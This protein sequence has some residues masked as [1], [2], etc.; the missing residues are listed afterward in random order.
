MPLRLTI[1]TPPTA[2]P[3]H[4]TDAKLHLRLATTAA[5]AALYTDEDIILSSHISAARMVA[6]TETWKALV[7]R[8]YDLVIDEWPC[9]EIA[10]PMPPLRAVDSITYTTTDGVEHTLAATEY[11]VD[12]TTH[13]GRVILG[14]DKEWPTDELT[15]TNP[16]RIRYRAG[17]AVP[18]T[19]NSTT[20]VITAVNHPFA[21][22]D[23]VRVSVTGGSLPVGLYAN[24]DYYA[25]DV[26]GNTLKLSAASGGTAIDITSAGTGQFFFGE[27]P[28]TT[29]IGMKLVI[30][31]LYE[32]R[33][34]TVFIRG[35]QL[36][37]ATL[38][39]AASHHFAMDSVRVPW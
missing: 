18:F 38:P 29:I 13:P 17:Y 30:S 4:L 31:D 6:E 34:D 10:L 23:V 19:V 27:I 36:S 11:D 25:R 1:H 3:I 35:G 8:K 20:D 2:E 24:T 14:Y 21:D 37:T 5:D 28:P 32:E 33:G 15:P 16:I 39:R 7:L 12:T 26:S 9:C 22:G